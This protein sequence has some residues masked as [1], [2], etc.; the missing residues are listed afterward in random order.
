MMC[1]SDLAAAPEVFMVYRERQHGGSPELAHPQL[2]KLPVYRLTQTACAHIPS[3]P[4]L[5]VPFR[6]LMRSTEEVLPFIYTPTGEWGVGA[7]GGGGVHPIPCWASLWAS[8]LAQPHYLCLFSA[9]V[10]CSD[11]ASSKHLHATP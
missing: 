10:S 4:A 1:V 11:S 2:A 8:L 5:P 9:P 6:L 7:A 3:P